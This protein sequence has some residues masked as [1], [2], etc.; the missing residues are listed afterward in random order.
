MSKLHNKIG[1]TLTKIKLKKNNW[2]KNIAQKL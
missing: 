1:K 2:K